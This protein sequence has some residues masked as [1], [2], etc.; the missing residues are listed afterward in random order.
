MESFSAI[1]CIKMVGNKH[2]VLEL[3]E[4]TKGKYYIME[5]DARGNKDYSEEMTDLSLALFLFDIRL[6]NLQGN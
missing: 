6:Q 2:F 4:S 3:A 1:K 5:E